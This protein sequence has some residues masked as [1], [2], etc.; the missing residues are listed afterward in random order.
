MWKWK[1]WGL[2]LYVI[3]ALAALAY[4]FI[5]SPERSQLAL[6]LLGWLV[7]MGIFFALIKPKLQYFH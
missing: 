4:F 6:S 5:S 2:Y 3:T 7:A 1:K